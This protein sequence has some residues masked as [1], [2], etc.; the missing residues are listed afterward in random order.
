MYYHARVAHGVTQ[1]GLKSRFFLWSNDN[2]ELRPSPAA[3]AVGRQPRT[4]A[5]K[6]SRVVV[7]AAGTT[8]LGL[9]HFPSALLCRRRRAADR[10]S[11]VARTAV[12]AWS[13]GLL[14]LTFLGFFHTSIHTA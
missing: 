4:A 11:R 2:R 9:Y 8:V 1:S 3:A 5:D 12:V 7:L 6:R 10:R 14:G 13:V